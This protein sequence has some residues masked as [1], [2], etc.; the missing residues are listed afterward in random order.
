MRPR[1][2]RLRAR[3]FLRRFRRRPG[4]VRHAD[5]RRHRRVAALITEVVYRAALLGARGAVAAAGPVRDAGA[6]A[7]DQG[8]DDRAAIPSQGARRPSHPSRRRV[9]VARDRRTGGAIGATLFAVAGVAILIG[10]GVWQL[11]RKVWKEN[12]IATL[13]TRLTRAPQPLPP[14]DSWPALKQDGSEY[15]RVSLPAE[16]LAGQEA[17]VYT[18]GS[19][20]TET[21]IEYTAGN[22]KHSVPIE[23]AHTD[24]KQVFA[25]QKTAILADA[26]ETT[27]KENGYQCFV[28]ADGCNLGERPKRAAELATQICLNFIKEKLD[29]TRF[30]TTRK[31]AEF[32]LAAL[33]KTHEALVKDDADKVGETTVTIGVV[34][35]KRLIVASVGDSKVFLLRRDK[36]RIFHCFDVT[37]ESR[38]RS[39][40][41]KDP[42]GRLGPPTADW[43]NLAIAVVTLEDGDIYIGASDGAHDNFS[44]ETLETPRTLKLNKEKWKAA[45]LNYLNLQ[46]CSSLASVVDGN[47]HRIGE[48]VL[49][50]V[51]AIT[52]KSNQ[53]MIDNPRE[54]L[55]TDI[56]K[57]PGK[58]DHFT[59]VD[60]VYQPVKK[61]KGSWFAK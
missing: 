32:A 5:R 37:K 4:G 33:Q 28:V 54:D 44:P 56:K 19:L 38:S 20:K 9:S 46:L 11:D 34:V 39:V 60:G 24:F 29:K 55:P 23:F 27:D 59:L 16:F 47:E 30:T 61:K 12:L 36:N 13:D 15:T 43:R 18:A 10:L 48:A 17:L 50:R 6:V 53:F 31:I 45:S 25:V 14:R 58:S 40:N 26:A 21:R 42:G 49:A 7:A 8:P 3:L 35:K 2:E 1:C 52:Q 51:K 57:F 41:A 22:T